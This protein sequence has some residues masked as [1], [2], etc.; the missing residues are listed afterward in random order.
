MLLDHTKVNFVINSQEKLLRIFK[1]I[2][3]IV[4]TFLDK[5]IVA[6]RV[7]LSKYM[8]NL[9]DVPTSSRRELTHQ[10]SFVISCDE[11]DEKN[12][13][14]QMEISDND[15]MDD[16]YPDDKNGKEKNKAKILKNAEKAMKELNIR[17]KNVKCQKCNERAKILRMV[18]QIQKNN[19]K[20]IITIVQNYKNSN[21]QEFTEPNI[22]GTTIY[23]EQNKY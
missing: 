12:V 5:L 13:A 2:S 23:C 10:N 18:Q 15:K 9:T 4:D 17:K 6:K 22:I 8:K 14:D 20:G 7:I 1:Q 16:E 19:R 11:S 3:A 21:E